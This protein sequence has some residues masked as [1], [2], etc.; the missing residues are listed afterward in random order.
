MLDIKYLRLNI[1]FVSGKMFERGQEMNRG[2][3]R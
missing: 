3:A 2:A 1:D